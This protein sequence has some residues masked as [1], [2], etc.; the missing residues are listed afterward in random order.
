MRLIFIM[1]W[2]FQKLS[3]II[4]DYQIDEFLIIFIIWERKLNFINIESECAGR[5][6]IWIFTRFHVMA[7]LRINWGF[8]F[9]RN[10]KKI[11]LKTENREWKISKEAV[12]RI[13]ITKIIK[14]INSNN[15]TITKI[16]KIH[17]H[18]VEMEIKWNKKV[19]S[20]WKWNLHES[21]IIFSISFDV[22]WHNT[23]NSQHAVWQLKK[24]LTCEFERSKPKYG[25]W[26]FLEIYLSCTDCNYKQTWKTMWQKETDDRIY[27]IFKRNVLQI[28]QNIFVQTSR[29]SICF[30]C[31]KK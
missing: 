19:G 31:K 4:N 6:W 28:W 11:P 21:A 18:N 14:S 7:E 13:V 22:E 27:I 10:D 17:S 2:H 3:I 5:N 1:T 12:K 26:A 16:R 20:E 15:N 8:H 24:S 25:T 23:Q 30:L 29:G 9:A